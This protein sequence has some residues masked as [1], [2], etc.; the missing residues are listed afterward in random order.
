MFP[1]NQKQ[2]TYAFINCFLTNVNNYFN[3]IIKV[4][5][6]KDLGTELDL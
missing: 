4:L 2:K 1:K 3:L 6:I 5:R